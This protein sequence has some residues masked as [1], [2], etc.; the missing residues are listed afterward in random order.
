VKRIRTEPH[1]HGAKGDERIR[2]AE[3][4]PSADPVYVMGCWQP[5]PIDAA[6]RQ[7]MLDE[8]LF[9]LRAVGQ[10]FDRIEWQEPNPIVS[11]WAALQGGAS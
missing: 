9:A 8:L 6:K 5:T 3:Q 2:T 11:G 1:D 7:W 4:A 10:P